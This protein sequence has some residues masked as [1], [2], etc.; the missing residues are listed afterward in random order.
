MDDH[1][2][3]WKFGFLAKCA[4]DGLT[5]EQTHERVRELI[6]RA[7]PDWGK[8]IGDVAV[9][10]QTLLSPIKGMGLAAMRGMAD[11]ALPIAGLGAAGVGGGLGLLAAK[12][13]DDDVD[14]HEVRKR[15]LINHY[16]H[17]AD[18]LESR[19]QLASQGILG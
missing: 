14:P 15:E 17:Y 4:Q 12:M 2:V 7:D 8:T 13:Q 1:A 9:A 3:N 6:K 18:Q 5:L 11:Y 19:R 16:N 10:G